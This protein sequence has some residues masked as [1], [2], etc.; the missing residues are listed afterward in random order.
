MTPEEHKQR[1]I[2]LHQALDQLLADWV[3]HHPMQALSN[4]T[5]PELMKWSFEQRENPT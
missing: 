2:E 3:Q 5:V 1:H 4:L